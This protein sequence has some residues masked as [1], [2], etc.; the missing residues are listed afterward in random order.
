MGLWMHCY[1]LVNLSQRLVKVP[2]ASLTQILNLGSLGAQ[3]G[4]PPAT[5]HCFI[6]FNRQ[7]KP[8]VLYQQLRPVDQTELTLS[9]FIITVYVFM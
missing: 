6:R 8:F 7:L 2:A 5:R 4:F 9:H 3:L 1:S